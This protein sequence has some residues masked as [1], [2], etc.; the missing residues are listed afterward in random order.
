MRVLFLS[1][2]HCDFRVPVS[3]ALFFSFWF[4]FISSLFPSL[5]FSF[6]IFVSPDPFLSSDKKHVR[7]AKMQSAHNFC[8]FVSSAS[9]KNIS[10]HM[11]TLWLLAMVMCLHQKE[12]TRWLKLFSTCNWLR[13]FWLNWRFFV[14]IKWGNTLPRKKF[15]GSLFR[16]WLY[17][18]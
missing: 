5:Y 16:R 2:F 17:I 9:T 13:I 8:L 7:L 4:F 15:T 3:F 14:I 6:P 12:S 1:Q 18:Y 10:F 11:S